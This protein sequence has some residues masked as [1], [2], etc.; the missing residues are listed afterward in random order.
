[1]KKEEYMDIFAYEASLTSLAIW[2]IMDDY[3][4]TTIELKKLDFYTHT[5]LQT[6]EKQTCIVWSKNKNGGQ[7]YI[8]RLERGERGEI[9]VDIS[10][11]ALRGSKL[12]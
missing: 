12:V 6:K 7:F 3:Q 11:V 9:E 4:P 5:Y 10:K 8:V 1:M 2:K